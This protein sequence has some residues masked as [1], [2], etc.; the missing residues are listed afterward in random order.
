M[1]LTW[2]DGVGTVLTGMIVA[3]YVA[4][5][6]GLE[7]P[8]VSGPRMLAAVVLV[9]GLIAC[10]LSGDGEANGVVRGTYIRLMSALG[11]TALVSGL[12][13]LATGNHLALAVLVGA[14]VLL[15]MIATVRHLSRAG[16]QRSRVSEDEYVSL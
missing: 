12:V 4:F 16:R 14:T 3:L 7:L 8:L 13:A 5:R 11:G 10:A 2:R 1:G 9:F 15:W 6:T